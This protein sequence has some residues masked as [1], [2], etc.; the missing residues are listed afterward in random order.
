MGS[1]IR[2]R[3]LVHTGRHEV[4][5]MEEMAAGCIFE[6]AD[7]FRSA[8]NTTTHSDFA[9]HHRPHRI[10]VPHPFCLIELIA[11]GQAVDSPR[12]QVGR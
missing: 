6:S 12:Q 1:L 10:I 2:V 9:Q 7:Y 11:G 4:A 5:E 8:D 3:D